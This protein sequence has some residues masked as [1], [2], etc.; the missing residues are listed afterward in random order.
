MNIDF[1]VAHSGARQEILALL[2]RYSWGY[3]E[4]DMELL[5]SV[6]SENGMTGGVVA[7]TDIGWGPWRGKRTIVDE[8]SKI[9]CSQ[10]DR[11]RH[12]LTSPVFEELSEAAA[13]VKV[14]LSLFSYSDGKAPHLVTTG[15][16][17]MKTSKS[18]H[19]WLID[20]L[21]EVLASPF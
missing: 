18:N 4:N 12:V 6:F 5:G 8:L 20:S 16:Y 11:R 21:E 15:E 19:G 10:S 1:D 2:Y 13:T 17:V 14:Y 9:R 7:D 3:D